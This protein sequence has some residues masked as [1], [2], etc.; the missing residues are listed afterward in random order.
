MTCDMPDMAQPVVSTADTGRR[1]TR[2]AESSA[3]NA[4]RVMKP[5]VDLGWKRQPDLSGDREISSA[6][7]MR[8]HVKHPG[9]PNALLD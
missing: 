3:T 5:F 2:A 8:C 6:L 7:R 9:Y 4:A 1:D